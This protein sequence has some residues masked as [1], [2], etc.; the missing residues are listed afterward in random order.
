MEIFGYDLD[1]DFNMDWESMMPILILWA[2]SL[3]MMWGFFF[4]Y[5]NSQ[6]TGK[7]A[8]TMGFRIFISIVLLPLSWII[9]MIIKNKD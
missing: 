5:W 4:P 6:V 3:A 9:G 1:F 8:L 7:A 2:I